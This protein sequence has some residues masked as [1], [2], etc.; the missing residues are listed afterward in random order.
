MKCYVCNTPENLTER[1]IGIFLCNDCYEL[2]LQRMDCFFEKTILTMNNKNVD[3]RR[4]QMMW[5]L[6]FLGL[7]FINV[8]WGKTTKKGTTGTFET[9]TYEEVEEKAKELR[10]EIENYGS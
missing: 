9:A 6:D 7:H 10:K 5:E 4:H 1:W 8:G 2:Y 3:Y